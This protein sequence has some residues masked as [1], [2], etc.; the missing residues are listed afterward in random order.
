MHS[1]VPVVRGITSIPDEMGVSISFGE[2]ARR[3]RSMYDILIALFFIAMV[4]SPA[5]IASLSRDGA[6]PDV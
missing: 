4:V 6:E 2:S 1:G 5:I 3:I